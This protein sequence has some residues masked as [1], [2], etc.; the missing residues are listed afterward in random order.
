MSDF[1]YVGCSYDWRSRHSVRVC[2]TQNTGCSE[3]FQALS[4]R[5]QQWYDKCHMVAVR[6]FFLLILMT[7]AALPVFP[8]FSSF[9]SGFDGL[10][11]YFT[12]ELRQAGADQP[13]YGKAFI[14]DANGIRPL[15]IRNR[16]VFPDRTFSENGFTTNFY[17][18]AG[19]SVASDVSQM[20]IVGLRECIG[21][22]SG[23]C[24]YPDSTTVY[25]PRGEAVFSAVG[26]LAVSPNGRW[27]L[28]TAVK[29]TAPYTEH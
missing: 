9:A 7:C 6:G 5:D 16:D 23:L 21:L 12:T 11:L 19:I 27:G 28:S 14:A 13:I 18:L 2:L 1:G 4:G 8:Q 25:D 20:A 29:L 17:N 22:T 3:F 15:L 26:H 10:R 24:Q